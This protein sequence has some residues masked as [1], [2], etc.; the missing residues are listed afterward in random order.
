[1]ADVT[2]EKSRATTGDT[3]VI[4]ETPAPVAR[5]ANLPSRGMTMSQVRARFGEPQS[6]HGPVGKPPITR[7]EY[8]DFRVVFEH[9]HVLT[10]VV[11][12]APSP[13]YHREQLQPK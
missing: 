13:I 11:P 7:W 5:P 6:K 9:S 4:E 2:A 3:L 10:A 8:P 1:M 12:G